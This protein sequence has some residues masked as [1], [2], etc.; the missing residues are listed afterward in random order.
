VPARRSID[1][2][3]AEAR[4][5][6]DRVEPA[7]LAVEVGAGAVIIDVRPVQQR[8]PG[9]EHPSAIVDA[10][11]SHGVVSARLWNA[12]EVAGPP[13]AR[14]A[15]PAHVGATTVQCGKCLLDSDQTTAAPPPCQAPRAAEPSTVEHVNITLLYFEGCPNWQPA[16]QLL[17]RLTATFPDVTLHRVTVETDD[18]AQQLEF[19]GS[20]TI[21]ID[22]IDP[23]PTDGS[24]FGLSCRR[25]TTPAGPAGCPTWDQ[26]VDAV[27]S[28]RA[29]PPTDCP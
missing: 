12:H 14:E 19:R 29:T 16:A 24:D 1:E 17:D 5:Q 13:K 2:L 25:F 27:S 4:S 22:G 7:S 9:G 3:L 28:L 26:L 11:L 20:P 18:Q 21:L 8:T 10:L 23:W 6:P 15:T